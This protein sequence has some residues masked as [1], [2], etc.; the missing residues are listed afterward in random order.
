MISIEQL[1]KVSVFNLH[2]RSLACEFPK[3]VSLPLLLPF[4]YGIQLFISLFFAL[5]N[6]PALIFLLLNWNWSLLIM[7]ISLFYCLTLLNVFNSK[8]LTKMYALLPLPLSPLSPPSP[9]P[10]SLF[11]F[12]A[13]PLPLFLFI[14]PVPFPYSLPP[15]CSPFPVT[16]F[17][18]P[19]F[20][21]PA[22]PF[23]LAFPSAFPLFSSPLP[24]PFPSSSLLPLSPFP[25]FLSFSLSL[26]LTPFPSSPSSCLPFAP[27]LS[28]ILLSS[29][30]LFCS[31]LLSS[32]LS[33][34]ILTK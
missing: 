26:Y 2:S 22:S 10:V 21:F 13:S 30:L 15:P 1:S 17:L 7:K 4:S 29:P 31:P 11:P 20:P 27:L 25:P 32:P 9:F 8:M 18:P 3:T 28:F 6:R 12:I 23:S 24:L 14:S 16:L 33:V 34:F 19:F 5:P